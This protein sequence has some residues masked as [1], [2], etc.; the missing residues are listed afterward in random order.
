MAKL[1]LESELERQITGY[2]EA[3]GWFA[4]KIMKA[5]KRGLMDRF[6]LKDGVHLWAEIKRPG[7]VPRD[8]Q[9][10]RAK[11][12]RQHGAICKHWDNFDAAKRDLDFYSL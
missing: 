8:Q 7:E 12:M 9:E 2:A 6:F 5:S 4:I 3:T 11:V 10:L 1:I